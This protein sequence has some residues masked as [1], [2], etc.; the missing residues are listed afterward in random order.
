[1]NKRAQAQDKISSAPARAAQSN[2]VP[3]KCSCGAP[4]GMAGVCETCSKERLTGKRSA[5]A[6]GNS[7]SHASHNFSHMSVQADE[8]RQATKPQKSSRS[9]AVVEHHR[10]Q[11]SASIRRVPKS[12]STAR[13]FFGPRKKSSPAFGLPQNDAKK[14]NEQSGPID[15]AALFA[16][17]KPALAAPI[18]ELQE[19]ET[20]RLPDVSIPAMAELRQT[21]NPI[22]STLTYNPSINQSGPPPSPFGETK[23]YTHTLSGISVSLTG[24]IYRVTATLDNPITFQVDGGGNTDIASETDP[25]I[26]NSNYPTV[27]SDLTPDMSDLNGAPPR[28]QFWAE[29]LTIR[30][31]RFHADEDVV[32]GRAG[33]VAAQAWLNT[34]TAST[35]ADVRSL[36]GA[37]PGRVAATVD[38]AMAY[39]GRE[40]RAYGDGAPL[41]LERANAIKAKGEA[42]EYAEGGGPAPKKGMSRGEKVGIGLLAGAIGGAAIGAIGGPIGALIG[43]GIGAVA[44]LIG[45]LL[46]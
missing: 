25:D 22:A 36:L 43:A 15:F 1:M 10:E 46:A 35:V 9:I 24:G 44:G 42:G 45:G 16:Q 7:T 33:V 26:T 19:G 14:G 41:Y 37:V 4:A 2:L 31:E 40:E 34:Q 32:H 12:Q 13:P 17:S 6:T 8:S 30:H 3:Q 21:D 27:V 28:T 11:F 29:D 38:A 20:I 23:P 5:N 18:R 39:P